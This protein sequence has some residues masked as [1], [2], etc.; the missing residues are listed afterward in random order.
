MSEVF[1]GVVEVRTSRDWM[2]GASKDV[3]AR[4]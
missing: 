3:Y 4:L 1:R 2:I